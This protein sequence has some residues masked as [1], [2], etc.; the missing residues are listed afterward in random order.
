MKRVA[1]GKTIGLIFG[2]VGLIYISYYTNMSME[3]GIGV[4]FL[5]VIT[6][7]LIGMVGVMNKH[8]LL[9]F[10]MPWWLRGGLMGSFMFLLLPLLNYDALATVMRDMGS[11]MSPYWAILD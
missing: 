1:L 7:A 2:L 3:F 6:G 9:G 10:K 8:P 4:L 5:Y 11:S